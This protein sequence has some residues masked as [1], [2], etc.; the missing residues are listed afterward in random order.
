MKSSGGF[1]SD[2]LF[3]GL[4]SSLD[5]IAVEKESDERVQGAWDQLLSTMA[6]EHIQIIHDDF[7]A[8]RLA[9]KNGEKYHL[10]RLSLEA[11]RLIV[12]YVTTQHDPDSQEALSLPPEVAKD[13]LKSNSNAR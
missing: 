3:E 5:E 12:C 8:L 6:P 9:R 10:N 13:Y 2:A 11:G 7:A 4:L 1:N